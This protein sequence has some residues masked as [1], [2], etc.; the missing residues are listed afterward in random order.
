M[1]DSHDH[2]R[3]CPTRS[4]GTAV[5]FAHRVAQSTCQDKQRGRFHKC[6]TCAYNNAYVAQHGLPE[7]AP[8]RAQAPA[9]ETPG[10]RTAPLLND[11]GEAVAGDSGRDAAVEVEVASTGAGH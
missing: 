4:D 11:A 8:L 6:Y 9:P 10:P 1:S 5:L 7:L 2:T 3:V